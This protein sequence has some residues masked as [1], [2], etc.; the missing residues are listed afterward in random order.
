M[1][2]PRPLIFPGLARSLVLTHKSGR[3]RTLA[4]IHRDVDGDGIRKTGAIGNTRLRSG[5]TEPY[6][7]GENQ[8]GREKLSG[9]IDLAASISSRVPLPPCPRPRFGTISA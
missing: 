7:P 5:L 1:T 6:A 2:L 8:T 9:S 4:K 3:S